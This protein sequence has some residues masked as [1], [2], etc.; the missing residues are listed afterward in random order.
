MRY[1]III[2]LLF[3]FTPITAW[4]QGAAP[5]P[6]QPRHTAKLQP[7]D[8]QIPEDPALQQLLAPYSS[9]VKEKMAAVIGQTPEAITKEGTAAGRLGRLMAT[10][11]Q[12]QAS[13]A[14]NRLVDFAIQNNGGIRAEIPAGDITIGT[15]FRLMPFENAIATVE[16]SGADLQ[17]LFNSMATA[18]REFGPGVAGVELVY[19]RQGLVSAKIGGKDLDPKATYVV[20]LTDYLY[21]GGGDYPILQRGKNYQ[22]FGLLRDSIIDYIKTQQTTVGKLRAPEKPSVIYK[23]E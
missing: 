22:A 20:G 1:Y 21:Q 16:M 23:D 10:I 11:I 14:S 7:I 12:T 17:E 8:A 9:T 15:V 13:K 3:V 18:I 4:A 19:N 2:L 6:S 5:A